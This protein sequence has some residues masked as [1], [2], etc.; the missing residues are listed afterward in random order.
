MNKF[1]KTITSIV[2]AVA[3]V[4]VL[5]ASAN[6]DTFTRSLTVGSRGADV[7]TLQMGLKAK[8]YLAAEATGYFGNLTKA[9]VAAFQTANGI[10]PAAGYFG[11]LSQAKWNAATGTGSTSTVPGCT[12]SGQLFSSTTGASCTGGSTTTT[13]LKGTDGSIDTVKTLSQYN[14]EEVGEG[15]KAV[16]VAGF[17]VKASND[18]DIAI[19]SVKLTFNGAT[20]SGSTKLNK[21]VDSVSLYQGSTKL[22]TVDVADFT[23]DSSVSSR[24]SKTVTVS[25]SVVKSDTKEK[26]Y[27]SVDG[28]TTYDSSD[29]SGDAWTVEVTNI[30][31]EDG[32]GV[33]S[34]DDSTG[35]IG[36]DITMDF[37]SFATS[38]NTELKFSTDAANPTAG[39][40]VVDD[41]KST[42]NVVLTKGKIKVEG[43]SD[44]LLDKLPVT[45]TST[46]SGIVGITSSLKLTI[47]GNDYTETVATS[48]MD[49]LAVTGLVGTVS[50]DNLDI[51]LTAG[52]T[53]SFTVS[54]DINDTSS[55]FTTGSTIKADVTASNRNIADAENSQGDQLARDTTERTGSVVGNAQTLQ[56]TGIQV[57]KVSTTASKTTGLAGNGD[58]TQYTM[59]FKIAAGDDDLFIDKSVQKALSPST[60]GAGVAFATTTTSGSAITG[61]GASNF[62]ADKMSDYSSEDTSNNFMIRAGSERTFTLNVTYTATANGYTGVKLTGIN[63]ATADGASDA[64]Y[65]TA[66]LS[67]FTTTDV[68]M[69][70]HA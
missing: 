44:I 56:T 53:Y 38:A 15:E 41:I 13:T 7:T 8:G 48:T 39:V 60:A 57:M 50:F 5:S 12:M 37:V 14:N 31:Y 18:G 49:S 3:F 19:R 33:V 68:Y 21:Y 17:E 61:V 45:L 69:E 26:F 23:K 43:T 28:A 47:D 11:P 32:S 70:L 58:T 10:T 62:T 52:K 63:Y 42:D 51:T 20:N 65:Y 29:I 24:W 59:V 22:A 25:N 9:A 30:R 6:A 46:G 34:T 67:D 36:S 1:T 64:S 2:S 16:K 27:I 4:A 55:T 40:V 54:A 35:D 66:N